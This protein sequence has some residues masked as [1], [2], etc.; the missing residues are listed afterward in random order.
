MINNKQEKIKLTNRIRGKENKY[1][2][3]PNNSEIHITNKE[4]FII[5]SITMKENK[6]HLWNNTREIAKEQINEEIS[7]QTAKPLNTENEGFIS[8]Y[9]ENINEGLK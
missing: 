8:Q 1:L 3:M 6:L 2:Y 5:A 9:K 7:V 4:G